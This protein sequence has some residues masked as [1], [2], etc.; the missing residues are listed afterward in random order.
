ML[1][2]M[3]A[4]ASVCVRVHYVQYRDSAA[5]NPQVSVL[6]NVTFDSNVILKIFNIAIK[7][8]SFCVIIVKQQRCLQQRNRNQ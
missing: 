8:K 1:V 2:C 6:E 4:R 3:R 7:K 5:S